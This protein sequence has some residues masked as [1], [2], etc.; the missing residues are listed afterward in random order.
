MGKYL[1]DLKFIGINIKGR[2]KE[3]HIFFDK[4]NNEIGRMEFKFFGANAIYK[5]EDE[6]LK[7]IKKGWSTKQYHL[8]KEDRPLLSGKQTFLSRNAYFNLPNYAD[9]ELRIQGYHHPY[10]LTDINKKE[11]LFTIGI[12]KI[13]PPDIEIKIISDELKNIP[14]SN[15]IIILVYFTWVSIKRSRLIKF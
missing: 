9:L 7:L 4:Q 5:S 2:I 3:I 13:A 8:I 15:Y 1:K 12:T 6:E 10:M 14:L 11:D